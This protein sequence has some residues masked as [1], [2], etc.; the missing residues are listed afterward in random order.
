MHGACESFFEELIYAGANFASSPARIL[1]DFIEPLI[2]AK[3]IATT[4]NYKY[5]TVD[6]LAMYLRN[7]AKGI[8]G[9]GAIGKKKCN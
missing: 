4:Q 6:N 9:T 8:G 2:V 7:G 1:I 5:I 3:K